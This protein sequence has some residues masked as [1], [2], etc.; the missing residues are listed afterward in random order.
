MTGGVPAPEPVSGRSILRHRGKPVRHLFRFYR[1]DP[2]DPGFR[3]GGLRAVCACGEKRTVDGGVTS[4]Q[5]VKLNRQH[6]GKP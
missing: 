1:T 4:A 3:N 2:A 5:L 6:A